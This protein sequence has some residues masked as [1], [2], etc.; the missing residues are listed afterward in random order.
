MDYEDIKIL[1]DK[2]WRCETTLDEELRLRDYFERDDIPAELQPYAGLFRYYKNVSGLQ[3]DTGFN[4]GNINPRGGDRSGEGSS[5]RIQARWYY[6]AAA[7]I[8]ILLSVF[9]IHERLT[10]VRQEAMELSRDTFKNPKVALQETKKV[11]MM[12]SVQMHKGEEQAVKISEFNK[13]ENTYKKN[14]D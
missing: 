10:R 9:I 7:V 6:R 2:Y 1:L 4:M 3:P 8:L 12:I 11:L 14:N 5:F 13:A